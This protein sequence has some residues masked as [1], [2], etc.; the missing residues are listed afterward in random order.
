MSIKECRICYE[1]ETEAEKAFIQPCKCKGSSAYV[2]EECLQRWRNTQPTRLSYLQCQ[3]C[4]TY[5]NIGHE[6]P[7]ERFKFPICIPLDPYQ[8]GVHVLFSFGWMCIPFIMLGLD[9]NLEIVRGT[10]IG[11]NSEDFIRYLKKTTSG[12]DGFM[13][14]CYYYCLC[15]YISVTLMQLAVGRKVYKHI[16]NKKRYWN[17]AIIPYSGL[18]FFNSHFMYL[19]AF[20][21][22]N[23]YAP[24]LLIS[25]CLSF[26]SFELLALGLYGHNYLIDFLNRK[27]Q[28]RVLNYFDCVEYSPMR[29]YRHNVI[30]QVN[31]VLN[32]V[33][34][35]EQFDNSEEFN[36]SE[37]SRNARSESESSSIS[38]TSV[39]SISTEIL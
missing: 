29:Q 6:Y 16:K 13:L 18:L 23:H 3:E 30:L 1:D 39:S 2:H 27:N 36:N 8:Y 26:F 10:Y 19:Y 11:S 25:A 32:D 33:D 28:E 34:T 15:T 4:N 9:T 14:Y 37:E 20:T 7:V 12:N 22:D 31:N 21:L 5:Y 35:D 17:K 38:F 24:W